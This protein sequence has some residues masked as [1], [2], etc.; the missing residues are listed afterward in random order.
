MEAAL[1]ALMLAT[2]FG[3]EPD[4]VNRRERRLLSVPRTMP[5]DD[6]GRWFALIHVPMLS[7]LP[8]TSHGIGGRTEAWARAG[9]AAFRVVHAG[10]HVRL[11]GHPRNEFHGPVSWGPIH[12]AAPLGAFHFLAVAT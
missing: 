4:A 11:A 12:G 2:L 9:V 10:L 5:K 8:W 3:H 6:A 1:H 7:A